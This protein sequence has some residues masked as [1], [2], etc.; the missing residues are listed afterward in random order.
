[1]SIGKSAV[2]WFFRGDVSNAYFVN[3]LREVLGLSPIPRTDP[4]V[5]KNNRE[6]ESSE[7]DEG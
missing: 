5:E 3:C 7:S 1:M 4:D 6:Q 2:P